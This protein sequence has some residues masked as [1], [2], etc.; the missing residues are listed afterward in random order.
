MRHAILPTGQRFR[1]TATCSVVNNIDDGTIAAG[2]LLNV[3]QFHIELASGFVQN[4]RHYIDTNDVRRQFVQH[5]VH[6]NIADDTRRHHGLGCI[7]ISGKFL[8]LLENVILFSQQEFKFGMLSFSVFPQH[9]KFIIDCV[10]LS[11]SSAIGQLFIFYTISKFGAVVFS[12][13]MTVRQVSEA[14]YFLFLSS[15]LFN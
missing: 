6:R 7:R 2:A 3:R 5:A 10:I 9:P 1:R 8:L 13:I 11:I 12:I 14:C 4:V 15:Q